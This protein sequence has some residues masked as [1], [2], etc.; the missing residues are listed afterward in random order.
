MW[1]FTPE[2]FV[3]VVS[4]EEFGSELQVR[5]RSEGDLERLRA[6]WFPE[7]GETRTIA[8]RDYPFRALCAKEDLAQAL[9]RMARGIDYT[10]FK[11]TV[12]QRHSQKRAKIYSKVWADCL[13]IEHEER[14][15]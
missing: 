11:D 15:S 3:S 4:G 7:L 14:A 13:A 12:A 9:A 8:G 1:L 2:G 5:A 10:N 6:S